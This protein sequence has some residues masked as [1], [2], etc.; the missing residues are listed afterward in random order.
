MSGPVSEVASMARPYPTSIFWAKAL[1]RKLVTDS[2]CWRWTGQHTSD[3]YGR[4]GVGP[5][6]A[7]E[8]RRVHRVSW[9]IHFGA[10]TDDAMVCHRCDVRD[11]FNPEH[12]FL[13]TAADNMHD[14]VSKGRLPRGAAR[15]QSILRDDDV[16]QMRAAM[17][18]GATTRECARRFGVSQG[19]VARVRMR[20]TWRH[21]P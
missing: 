18:A 6:H 4:V 10:I 13:G 7:R 12:L 16:R 15:K 8:S 14:C 1:A 11:C 19:C 5:D 17:A 2:G 3:G 21:I 9:E 20:A